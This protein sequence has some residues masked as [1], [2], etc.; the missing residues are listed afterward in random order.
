[1]NNL[2]QEEIDK[3]IKMILSQTNFN[4]EKALKLLQENNYNEINV[5]KIYLGISKKN[6]NK[7]Q[8]VN[9]EIYKQIRGRMGLVMKEYNNNNPLNIDHVRENFKSYEEN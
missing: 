1:M 9:Q 6:D 3:K 7:I 5:I 4:Q 2:N 8:S